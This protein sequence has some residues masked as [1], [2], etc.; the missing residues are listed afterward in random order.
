MSDHPLPDQSRGCRWEAASET[1]CSWSTRK[2]ET[3]WV[4]NVNRV[5]FFLFVRYYKANSPSVEVNGD[6]ETLSFVLTSLALDSQTVPEKETILTLFRL[7][8][9]YS[10]THL[11]MY[12]NLKSEEWKT[13]VVEQLESKLFFSAP[14]ITTFMVGRSV[15]PVGPPRE[16]R[17]WANI[18]GNSSF[19]TSRKSRLTI[20]RLYRDREA[21]SVKIEAGD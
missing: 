10:S 11:K 1:D 9:T 12:T 5:F 14:S 19:I 13:T 4:K 15:C 16:S 21:R 3:K 7:K 18:T 2:K 20:P 17:G 8:P 6:K